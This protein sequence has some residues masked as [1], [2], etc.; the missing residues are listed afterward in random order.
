[1]SQ[2]DFVSRGQAL[3]ASGQFQEAVKVCRL[4]LLGRPTTVEGRVVLGQALLAL[5]RFDEVLAEMRVAIELDHGAVAAHTLKAEALLKKGDLAGALEVLH[6]AR[7]LAPADPRVMQLLGEAEHGPKAAGVAHPSASFIGASDT[8]HYPGQATDPAEQQDLSEGFTKPTSLAMPTRS[9]KSPAPKRKDPTPPPAVLAVGDKSGTVEV[10]PAVDSIDDKDDLD[11]DDLAAPPVRGPASAAAPSAK[12]AVK[13]TAPAK[14]SA[15]P[16]AKQPSS[17]RTPTLDIDPDDDSDLLEVEE[18]AGRPSLA[19]LRSGSAVREAVKMP[20]GPIDVDD[21]VVAPPSRSKPRSVVPPPSTVPAPLGF[22]MTLPASAMQHERTM[23]APHG[24]P[25]P[26]PPAAPLPPAP[27]GPVVAALP[28]MAAVPQASMQQTL[29]PASMGGHG[30]PSQQQLANAQRKTIAIAAPPPPSLGTDPH[31]QAQ[32][33]A[34]MQQQYSEQHWPAQEATMRPSE[35][36]DPHLQMLMDGRNSAQAMPPMELQGTPS[37]TGMRRRSKLSIAV[38]IVIGIAV[39]GGGVFA[40]FQIRS[41]RLQKQIAAAR[42]HAT[43]LAKADTWPGWSA[44]E[45][46]LAGIVQASATLGNRAALARAKALIAYELVDNAADAKTTVE[47]LGTNAGHDGEIAAAYMALALEDAKAAKLAADAAYQDDSSDPASSYL[48]GQ[49]WLQLGDVKAAVKS[50]K[51]AVDK[52]PRPFFALGLSR[53]LEAAYSWDDAVASIDRATAGSPDHPAAAIA[54]ASLLADAGRIGGGVAGTMELRTVLTKIVGDAKPG[55]VASPAQGAF[56]ALALAR[57][58][59]ARGDSN[60]A[61]GDVSTAAG[62]HLDDQ[63]F[64]EAAVDTLFAIAQLKLGEKAA[65]SALETFPNSRR[66]QLALARILAGEGQQ[67]AALDAI[68]KLGELP[69]ATVALRGHIKL[70]AGDV[71]GARADFDAA[72]QKQ[73]NLEPAIVGQALLELS[74]GDVEAARKLIE[75]RVTDK[76]ASPAISIAYAAILRRG[77]DAAKAKARALL[78]K[79]AAGMAGGATPDAELELARVYRDTGDFSNARKLYAVAGQAGNGTAR[80]EG[81]V[82]AIDDR[83]PAGGRETLDTLLKAAGD[84]PS[85]ELV[86]ETARARMLVGDH[87]GAASLLET[88]DKLPGIQKWK[89]AREKGRLYLRRGDLAAAIASFSTALDGCGDDSETFLLA[90]DA[91]TTETTPALGDKL[92]KVLAERV[93]NSPVAQIATGKLLLQAGGKDNEADA[94]Y[95]GARDTLR[96][97]HAAARLI[98]QADYGLAVVAYNKSADQIALDELDSVLNGDPSLYDAYLFKADLVKDKKAAYALAQ[99]A[100]KYN[101][102]YPRAWSVL[103]R[104][105]AKNNDKAALANAIVMLEKLAPTSADLNDLKKLR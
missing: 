84:Q 38:W 37:R 8:K 57:I 61:V 52:D 27:R 72:L 67:R 66:V 55:G 102:D 59:F 90:A 7:A 40:G 22:A 78:E 25:M 32:Q 89:L 17:K 69:P 1:M 105:A 10:D 4:G 47:A 31:Y 60:A 79:L 16:A 65:H 95:R 29:I 39:I 88:A 77:D 91:A 104:L 46:S 45:G 93:K 100:V 19:S 30:M 68:A 81:A 24:A 13:K 92:K 74:S 36:I 2:S 5:K 48:V 75:P 85:P 41:V 6:T 56:A 3:V 87:E 96:A 44:A 63:R 53:A 33:H 94:A 99:T 86:L 14:R 34:M 43:D 62:F 21:P 97:Q 9:G 58:D 82:M 73:A 64:A 76:G 54:R 51:E 20:S 71:D 70:A 11:F 42:E 18:T 28:T 12:K 80:L 23:P 101:P 26:M 35:S 49:A 98:A 103:G 15:T 50:A 83:D